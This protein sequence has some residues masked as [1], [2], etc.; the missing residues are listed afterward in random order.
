M[1]NSVVLVN[2]PLSLEKRYGN[3][4]AQFEAVTEPLGLAAFYEHLK[5]NY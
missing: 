5:S 2:P 1:T 3:A 4:M